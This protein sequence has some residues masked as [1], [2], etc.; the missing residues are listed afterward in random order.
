MYPYR[1]GRGGAVELGQADLVRVVAALGVRCPDYLGR[2]ERHARA[3]AAT[4]RIR[5]LRQAG[6]VGRRR[7]PREPIPQRL[8]AWLVAAGAR[9]QR[10]RA[11]GVGVASPVV[12][13]PAA[14]E[15]V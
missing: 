1:T 10:G 5:Q 2:A 14:A 9:L 12:A 13:G 8:G 4:E 15:P 3:L 7:E 11:G 6:L